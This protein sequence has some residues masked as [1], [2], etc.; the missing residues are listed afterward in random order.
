[1]SAFVNNLS[2]NLMASSHL[3]ALPIESNFHPETTVSFAANN[4]PLVIGI[5]SAYVVFITLGSMVMAKMEK[6]FDLRL[7]LA[8]WNAFLCV[9]SFV[10]MVKTVR[11]TY[12][13]TS[14]NLAS[15]NCFALLMF[16][17]CRT[18]LDPF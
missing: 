15:S 8:G 7:S 16:L 2:K 4:W 12:S 13:Y 18:W 5:V 10:G 3:L 9:F 11:H 6:P 17:R 14:L 1:M